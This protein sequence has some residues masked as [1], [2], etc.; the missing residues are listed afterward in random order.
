[1]PPAGGGSSPPPITRHGRRVSSA[2]VLRDARPAAVLP[3]INK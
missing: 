1:M 2:S 3:L